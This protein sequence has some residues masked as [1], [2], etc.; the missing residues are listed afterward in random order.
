MFC[1]S[2]LDT[3]IQMQ[4]TTRFKDRVSGLLAGL[5]CL[6]LLASCSQAGHP[7][8]AGQAIASGSSNLSSASS[9]GGGV[10]ATGSIV[11]RIAGG[12]N[13]AAKFPAMA[14]L[15]LSITGAA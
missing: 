12:T 3:A 13:L 8:A 2:E 9:T 1:P 10:G 5:F 6:L 14:R 11:A 15:Q 4:Q 7:S